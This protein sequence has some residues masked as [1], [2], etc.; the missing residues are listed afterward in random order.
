MFVNRGKY[1][2]IVVGKSIRQ[3]LLVDWI[4]FKCLAEL[5][6]MLTNSKN[7]NIKDIERRKRMLPSLLK[8]NFFDN[9]LLKTN[10]FANVVQCTRSNTFSLR[11]HVVAN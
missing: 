3:R 1:F 11:F 10:S 7:N 2:P 5:N 6:K 9:A 4:V 8:T